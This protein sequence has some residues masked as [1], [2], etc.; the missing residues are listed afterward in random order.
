MVRVMIDMGNQSD[1]GDDSS[2]MI[3]K[4]VEEKKKEEDSPLTQAADRLL[5]KR[6]G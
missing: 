1:D 5:Y 3:K 2:E 4:I 6:Y